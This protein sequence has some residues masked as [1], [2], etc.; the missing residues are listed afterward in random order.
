MSTLSPLHWEPM[1]EYHLSI[2][3]PIPDIPDISYKWNHTCDPHVAFYV[4]FLT[5]RIVIIPLRIR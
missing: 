4:R 2:N 1:H 5:L 3:L